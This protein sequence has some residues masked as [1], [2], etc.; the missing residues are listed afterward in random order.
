[1][2]YQGGFRPRLPH[3]RSKQT[4]RQ[5]T[6]PTGTYHGTKKQQEWSAFRRHPGRK[7]KPRAQGESREDTDGKRLDPA[8][9]IPLKRAK[10][11][12]HPAHQQNLIGS[13]VDQVV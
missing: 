2:A 3:R 8:S 10:D 9:A 7:E 1:M 6:D 11:V 5:A 4:H 12:L 13:S